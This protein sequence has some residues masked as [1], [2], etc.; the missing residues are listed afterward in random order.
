MSFPV[1]PSAGRQPPR[2]SIS[3]S[4]SPDSSRRRTC[5]NFCLSLCDWVTTEVC[6][7][8]FDKNFERRL[9]RQANLMT[10]FG[11]AALL[12]NLYPGV[13]MLFVRHQSPHVYPAHTTEDLPHEAPS[14]FNPF[15]QAASLLDRSPG[16]SPLDI[17]SWTHSPT[18]LRSTD[19]G[20]H[21]RSPTASLP[22]RDA[23]NIRAS[24]AIGSSRFTAETKS[25]ERLNQRL[26]FASKKELG[27][28]AG[29][30]HSSAFR[31]QSPPGKFLPAG[32]AGMFR[33]Q[34]SGLGT[35]SSSSFSFDDSRL[36]YRADSPLPPVNSSSF[37]SDSQSRGV[38]GSGAEPRAEA[39]PSSFL[40]ESSTSPPHIIV[41]RLTEDLHSFSKGLIWVLA[42]VG[43]SALIPLQLSLLLCT[44]P[45]AEIR[46]PRRRNDC[47]CSIISV[48]NRLIV[49]NCL[50]S[51]VLAVFSA[52]NFDSYYTADVSHL[53][54]ATRLLAY[55]AVA[56]AVTVHLPLALHVYNFTRFFE[57]ATAYYQLHESLSA[58][59]PGSPF[60]PV[61]TPPRKVGR[62]GDDGDAVLSRQRILER[63]VSHGEAC[64]SFRRDEHASDGEE[65]SSPLLA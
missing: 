5:H 60:G 4:V 49:Y 61:L 7:P 54:V 52:I 58:V 53:S 15:K 20:G 11:V 30:A 8:P 26:P 36:R 35:P 34:A 59:P 28:G 65:E 13:L 14:H 33:Q 38:P 19:A 10:I 43:I 64:S 31:R 44:V 18:H 21:S 2:L 6:C 62:T 25:G 37:V 48:N 50:C 24:P 3:T 32:S 29:N 55:T 12:V 17:S 27:A 40:S 1:T 16:D 63:L 46:V 41:P 23:E 9:A 51:P 47:M 57:G 22:S 42:F 45:L 56:L 39:P